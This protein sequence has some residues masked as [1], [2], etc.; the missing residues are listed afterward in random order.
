MTIK[1]LELLGK[2]DEMLNESSRKKMQQTK[3]NAT[4]MDLI[5]K[6]LPGFVIPSTEDFWSLSNTDRMKRSDF[7]AIMTNL[8]NQGRTPV[9][10][11]K[12]AVELY[13]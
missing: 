6:E 9:E 12:R 7:W 11:A 3:W 8:F 1:S 5:K 13:K 2:I 4:L 10:A